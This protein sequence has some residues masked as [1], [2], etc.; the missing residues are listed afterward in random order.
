MN[1]PVL[2]RRS[3]LLNRLSRAFQNAARRRRDQ[4]CG[5]RA[6]DESHGNLHKFSF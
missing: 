3:E 6:T 1:R 2:A 4:P 5:G